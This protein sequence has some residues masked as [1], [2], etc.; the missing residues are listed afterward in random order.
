[1][2]LSGH[3]PFHSEKFA[4]V[5]AAERV[6]GVKAVAD[7][8]EVRIPGSSILDELRA[9][10]PEERAAEAAAEPVGAAT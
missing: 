3:V 4:A 2:T 8:I 7:E 9:E 5:R 6:F 1:V 10:S